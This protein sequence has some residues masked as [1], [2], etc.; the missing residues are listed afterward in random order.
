MKLD[1]EEQR[2]DL[3]QIVENSTR[4]FTN[5]SLTEMTKQASLLNQLQMKIGNAEIEKPQQVI[6][7]VTPPV[8]LKS[9]ENEGKQ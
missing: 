4:I 5:M 7:P 9:K 1:S 6:P 2:N 8:P 3:I